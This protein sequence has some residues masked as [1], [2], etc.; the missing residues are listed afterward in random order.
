MNTTMEG[1]FVEMLIAQR[2]ARISSLWVPGVMAG[3]RNLNAYA[4]KAALLAAPI[5]FRDDVSMYRG[6][7]VDF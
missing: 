2:A 7:L 1:S 3:W 6:G 4:L 5:E